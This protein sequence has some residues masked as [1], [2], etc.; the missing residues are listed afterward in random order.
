MQEVDK[1]FKVP[2]CTGTSRHSLA[3]NFQ[4]NK[5]ENGSPP[6]GVFWDIEN[7]QVPKG[8][9]AIGLVQQVRQQFFSGHREAE[10]LCVCDISKESRD[11][12]QELNLAQVT[13][14][15]IN[16]T[17]KNAADDKLKQC[18]RRF[19]D[20]HGSPSTVLLISGDVNF[21]TELSDF[22]HRRNIRII[23]L[24]SSRAPEPLLA[25]AHENYSFPELAS[26]IPFRSP[27]RGTNNRVCELIVSDLP[28]NRDARQIHNR[29]K[30]LSDNCGG[31]VLAV[32]G[33][34]A[35]LRFPSPEA[36]QRAKKRMDREDVFGTKISV[37]YSQ[38][39]GYCFNGRENSP[40]RSGRSRSRGFR[41]ARQRTASSG[42]SRESSPATLRGPEADVG[43]GSESSQGASPQHRSFVFPPPPDLISQ[44]HLGNKKNVNKTRGKK[45]SCNRALEVGLSSTDAKSQNSEEE[46]SSTSREDEK[47]RE[48][49]C[50][51]S[52]SNISLGSRESSP[53]VDNSVIIN[54]RVGLAQKNVGRV[55]PFMMNECSKTKLFPEKA[56][57]PLS[58][59]EALHRRSL[60][61]SVLENVSTFVGANSLSPQS[62]TQY[63]AGSP[64]VVSHASK[65][66]D[67]PA[68]PLYT[69]NLTMSRD[70]SQPPGR[71]SPIS[72]VSSTPVE[73][74]VTNL[75]QSIEA[76]EMKKI[77][78]SVFREHVMVIHI[79]LALQA[80]NSLK[81]IIKVPSQQ[82]AQYAIS[83]LHRRKIGYKRILISYTSSD[84]TPPL[85]IL[86]SEVVAL[87]SDVPT[88]KLPVFK[89]RELFEKRYHRS[90][91]VSELYK[92]KEAVHIVED[93]TGRMVGLNPDYRSTPSPV[94]SEGSQEIQQILEKPY[95]EQH[96]RM[97][98]SC[99]WAEKDSVY[100]LPD[101]F[102]SLKTL[103]PQVHTL[104]DTHQGTLPL[105]SFCA[106]YEAEFGLLPVHEGMKESCRSSLSEG[107]VG[108]R[109]SCGLMSDPLEF[110]IPLE[111]LI[112]CIPGVQITKSGLGVKKVQWLGDKSLDEQCQRSISPALV[113]QLALFSREMVDLLKNQP[114]SLMAF[115]KFIPAYHHHFGRQC[116][117][118]DYGFT[119]LIDLLESVPQVVQILGQGQGRLLTLTHRAQVKRF[120]ADLLRILKSQ[121]S[122]QVKLSELALLYEEIIGKKFVVT[123]YGVCEISDILVEV[124]ESSVVIDS[125]SEET[126]I[127]IPKRE[128]TSEEIERTK[129]FST[130]VIEL[131]KHSPTCSMSFNKFVPAYHHHFGKQ[132]RVSDYGFTKL[133]ELLE[134]ISDVLKVTGSGEDKIIELQ[135]SEKLRVMAERIVAVVKDSP[136]QTFLLSHLPKAY[137]KLHGHALH[138]EE[139]GCSSTENLV[140]KL[141]HAVKVLK[142]AE[143]PM[144]TLVDRGF[145]RQVSLRVRRLLMEQ[146]NGSSTIEELC[147]RY[148]KRYGHSITE[149]MVQ[150]D[151]GDV[152]Q[153]DND[154]IRL[155]PIQ[156]LA[157]DILILLHE[158]NGAISLPNF[159]GAY[160][161]RFG[162]P[163]RPAQYGFQSLVS[164]LQAIP[165][166]VLVKGRRS[167]RMILLN[168]DMAG[169]P[170]PPFL[171]NR[172]VAEKVPPTNV[173]AKHGSDKEIGQSYESEEL[174]HVRNS[175]VDLLSQPIP[176]SVPS[177]ELHPE[178]QS[179]AERDLMGFDSPKPSS[180]A[181]LEEQQEAEFHLNTLPLQYPSVNLT[182]SC[183]LP[184]VATS[185]SYVFDK[186]KSSIS[187]QPDCPV[188]TY[189]S[190]PPSSQKETLKGG[191][192]IDHSGFNTLPRNMAKSRPDSLSYEDL[193]VIGREDG[194]PSTQST[195]TRGPT[196][197]YP[198]S[199]I[200]AHFPIPLEPRY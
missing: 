8:R 14:V 165:D 49:G 59:V 161:Q 2:L 119:K 73:L 82:D 54:N 38:K 137:L 150:Q 71:A 93:V 128:Q 166:Y 10:F 99:G 3:A 190:L 148:L 61:P 32:N 105:N 74:Q 21:A 40:Q 183:P 33:A 77:L 175:P 156:L 113:G 37:N 6:I 86:R 44:S 76:N 132:C 16:A 5:T 114:R 162:V 125:T 96:F 69:W 188:L 42:S 122:K 90:I 101:V 109:S 95:C 124:A 164:M 146:L 200:A 15:H 26:T 126:V 169:S 123:N 39:S 145:V 81:A 19:V 196:K 58:G 141:K 108:V 23:L 107:Q 36:A 1:I 194:F 51:K 116:R 142:M 153:I 47:Q 53:K 170:L 91:G 78:F 174:L 24:H 149:S 180:P 46:S 191:T 195:P 70:L 160:F 181:L 147:Q 131:L 199:R 168:R 163:C 52:L 197:V 66:L 134:V 35:I 179:L 106:C 29:L 80:D 55:S 11:V 25:C 143:G 182:S 64:L 68:Q 87:L 84:R 127:A 167:K 30:Q 63:M 185:S 117:V 56:A 97:S 172:E 158:H 17:S 177:P 173:S 28:T 89:F 189:S 41:P 85:H 98:N 121:A 13:V 155:A 152:V 129:Q 57:V 144:I 67:I 140:S 92:M 22:R 102:I 31:R 34:T 50:N 154:V 20:I 171:T 178:L 112:A 115:S 110:G 157:R 9:S 43:S 138:C 48:R 186:L 18:M 88:R 65:S 198:R 176:S 12:I 7:C 75:D 27:V 72:T 100:P 79:S 130:E 120:A 94:D 192:C 184:A 151:L 193:T 104:L 111:H 103:A 187:C 118:A 4:K 133:I 62:F 139:Y 83:Q 135:E 159:E 136:N 45:G 60:T